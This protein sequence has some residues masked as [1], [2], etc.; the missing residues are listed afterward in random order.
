MDEVVG[1]RASVLGPEHPATLGAMADM[2][3]TLRDAGDLAGARQL[4]EKVAGV[5]TK[6]LG[7]EHPDTL[8]PSINVY[9]LMWEQGDTFE[10]CELLEACAATA[11]RVLGAHHPVTKRAEAWVGYVMPQGAPQGLHRVGGRS[12]AH[13]LG[14][15][16]RKRCAVPLLAAAA[17]VLAL[18]RTRPR[19]AAG[20]A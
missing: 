9:A 17:A 19:R 7:R 4:C 8:K 3:V 2:A 5:R 20:Q 1:A 13:L 10:A 16:G 12:L 18:R 14:P 6:V 15:F 11:A